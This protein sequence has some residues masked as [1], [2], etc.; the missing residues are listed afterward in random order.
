MNGK[1]RK[2]KIVKKIRLSIPV[3]HLSALAASL[4]MVASPASAQ[5]QTQQGWYVRGNLA[6][7]HGDAQ[8]RLTQG[9]TASGIPGTMY[10][11][12]PDFETKNA[13]AL[14]LAVGRQVIP[15]FRAEI[16]LRHANSD[17]NSD[18]LAGAAARSTDTFSMSGSVHSTSL[19]VNGVYDFAN[20]SAWTPYLK[21]GLGVTRHKSDANLT[22]TIQAMGITSPSPNL[23]PS[24]SRTQLTW[25]LGAGTSF[26]ITPNLAL[27]L[28]YRYI[29]MGT[30]KTGTDGFGDSVNTKMRAHDLSVGLAYRF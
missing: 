22:A 2:E 30:A 28:G 15:Q 4:L 17:F 8:G 11:Q 7:S 27:D 18:T 21:L 5:N 16:E 9:N 24:G 20:N 1:F 3:A 19:L 14:S 26:A 10:D 12:T 23:F 13:T 29:D 6:A 25:A